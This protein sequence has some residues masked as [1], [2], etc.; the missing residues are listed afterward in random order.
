MLVVLVILILLCS[1]WGCGIGGVHLRKFV[2]LLVFNVSLEFWRVQLIVLIWACGVDC[3][4]FMVLVVMVVFI[5][6]CL[7]GFMVL[8]VFI[9]RLL[10]F[11]VFTP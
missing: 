4:H 10:V 1:F 5:L 7:F 9:A 2:A 6:L 8:V 11:M 3:V